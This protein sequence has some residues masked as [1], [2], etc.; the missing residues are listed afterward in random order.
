MLA[1]WILEISTIV[2]ILYSFEYY[3]SGRLFRSTSCQTESGP[4]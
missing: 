2:F 1:F 3:L 4:S